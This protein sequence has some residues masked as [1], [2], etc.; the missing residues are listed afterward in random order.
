[1]L[2]VWIVDCNAPAT[3]KVYLLGGGGT[4][5]SNNPREVLGTFVVAREPVNHIAAAPLGSDGA[6]PL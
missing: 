5:E 6:N 2:A 1:M 4:I 3:P